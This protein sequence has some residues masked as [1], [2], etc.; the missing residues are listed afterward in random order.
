MGSGAYEGPFTLRARVEDVERSTN[1][2]ELIGAAHAGC[3][4]MSLANLL[5]RVRPSAGRSADDGQGPA[6]AARH[7]I[8]DHEHRASRRWATSPGSTPMRS[9]D[10]PSRR[11]TRAPCRVRSPAR[12]SRWRRSLPVTDPAAWT[13]P[14]RSSN[15]AVIECAPVHARSA[16]ATGEAEEVLFVLEGNG[17][18]GP[19]RRP[20]RARARVRRVS[21]A[22]ARSTSSTTRGLGRCASSR[23]GSTTRWRP[24]RH[25]PSTRA[26]VRRLADQE[27]QAATTVAHVPDRGRPEHRPSIGDPLRRL[28]ADGPGARPFPH[29]RR[30]HLRA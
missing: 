7:G 22:R 11:R 24:A 2:E 15:S 13:P 4:T 21:R 5:T 20:L 8:R 28:H 3:F 17:D 30:S 27:E 9:R 19:R 29:L 1:P 18:A 25:R 6:R 16:A 26:V 10:W 23:S 14:D 12:R